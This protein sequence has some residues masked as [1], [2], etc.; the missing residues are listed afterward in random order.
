MTDSP[1][2][3][4]THLTLEG[5]IEVHRELGPGLLEAVYER[6]L[7]L[8]L[9]SRGLEVER[10]VAIEATYRGESLGTSFRADLIVGG[11][12]LLELKAADRWSLTHVAQVRTYL[13]WAGLETGYLL[14]F[15]LPLM[16]QGIRRVTPR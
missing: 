11:R 13:K 4:L 2:D 7:L 1:K 3:E 8:E 14:N 9:R 6:A 12:L 15:H 16:S 5:A 10:Q